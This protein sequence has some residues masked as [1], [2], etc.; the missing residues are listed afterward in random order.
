MKHIK[1]FEDFSEEF[2][3]GEDKVLNQICAELRKSG[4]HEAFYGEEKKSGETILSVNSK[5][6]FYLYDSIQNAKG[7]QDYILRRK[8]DDREVEYSEDSD[9]VKGIISLLIK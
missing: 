5:N 6:M 1:L 8:D 7:K 2:A 3:K 9:D 4:Y